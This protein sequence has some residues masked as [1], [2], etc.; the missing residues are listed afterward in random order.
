MKKILIIV[1]VSIISTGIFAQNTSD[2]TQTNQK[3]TKQEEQAPKQQKQSSFKPSKIFFGGNVGF[4]FGTATTIR[5]N[6]LVGYSITPQLSAGISGMYEYYSYS[7]GSNYSNYG[8]SVFTRYRFIPQL[9]AHAEFYY[10]NYENLFGKSRVGVPYILLGGG[11]AQRIA[12][13][14][15]TYVQVLFDVL[16]DS[17]SPYSDWSPFYSIGVSVGF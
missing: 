8:G 11:Y 14:T 6:P 16:Q 2:T 13:N 4:S 5:L 1:V 3:Y 9:Y 10:V 17:N 12:K 15:Y 7:G